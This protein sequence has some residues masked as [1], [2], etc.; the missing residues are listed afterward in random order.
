MRMGVAI[1]E[2]RHGWRAV[3]AGAVGYA[4]GITTWQFTQS[5]FVP[6]LQEAFGW[7]RGAIAMASSSYIL[8]AICAPFIGRLADGFGVRRVAIAASALFGLV[9]LG[10]AVMNG[11]IGFYYVLCG[12]AAIIG[13]G[14][15]GMTFCRVVTSWFDTS[16]GVALAL[17]SAGMSIVGALLPPALFLV[18]SAYGWRAGYVLMAALPLLVAVPVSLLWLRERPQP[19][20]P[21]PVLA[22]AAPVKAGWLRAVMKWRVLLLCL[23]GALTYAP[24]SGIIGQLHPLLTGAGLEP[25][26]AARIVGLTAV[27][28]LTGMLLSGWLADRIW[29]PLVACIFTLGP[30]IG[31][32][33]LMGHALSIVTACIGV[34][35][36]GLAQGAEIQIIAYLIGRYFGVRNYATIF[37]LS[38][39][40]TTA[41]S[42]AFNVGF[43]AAYDRF[44]DYRAALV[45][46][47]SCFLVAA[48]CYLALGRYPRDRA[49]AQ[50]QE[51]AVAPVT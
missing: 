24:F 45:V 51:P 6:Q 31:C 30:V 33:L 47:A 23:A 14:T 5:L 16:R 25:S 3:L 32:I 36:I 13:M 18:M 9:S 1:S 29:A 21:A 17:T 49:G 7:S 20:A 27:S 28:S 22:A 39:F 38:V 35:L 4:T 46:A 50:V 40:T 19:A 42:A 34:V 10:L 12:L 2:W 44:G 15:T 8:A 37:G 43:G 48:L 41:L 26:V 11:N